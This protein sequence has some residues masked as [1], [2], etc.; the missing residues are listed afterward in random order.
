MVRRL[1]FSVPLSEEDR[2]EVTFDKDQGRVVAFMV[3]YVATFQGS[4]HSV[5]RYDTAHGFPHK[6]ICRPEGTVD[7]K[8]R[9]AGNDL[10][11][12][13]DEAIEDVKRNWGVYRRRFERWMP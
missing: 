5:V 3:N 9:M 8:E 7:H 10:L 1:R 6:D 11:A 4:D 13:A 12:L 2:V